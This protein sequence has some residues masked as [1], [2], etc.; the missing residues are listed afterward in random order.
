M[1]SAPLSLVFNAGAR[2]VCT[3]GEPGG[4]V[5]GVPVPPSAGVAP[6]G[7]P[8]PPRE[9]GK[10]GQ[11]WAE[12]APIASAS[13]AVRSDPCCRGT[14]ATPCRHPG[15]GRGGF[16]A[17]RGVRQL[18]HPRACRGMLWVFSP[19]AL[20]ETGGRGGAAAPSHPTEGLR[21]QARVAPA[22]G[23]P[24]GPCLCHGASNPGHKQEADIS[25]PPPGP[26]DKS[27]T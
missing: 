6:P 27:R 10:R 18:S 1:L 21:G 2:W 9:L 19:P 13:G 3:A 25:A 12:A 7:T 24:A 14:A 23:G 22:R 5:W 26:L 15:Q 20:R 16:R 11:S 4:R 8:T 17:T